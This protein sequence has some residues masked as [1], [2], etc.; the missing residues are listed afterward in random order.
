M[1]KGW[2]VVKAA[3]VAPPPAA[4]SFCGT[5]TFEIKVN[6][7]S[8][9][10]HT[11]AAGSDRLVIV[12]FSWVTV[13]RTLDSCTYGGVTMTEV[14]GSLHGSGSPGTKVKAFYLP[15][16]SL[17][18]NGA[19]V[20]DP[21]FSSTET[22]MRIG[23]S[24]KC[25]QDVPSPT[26]SCAGDA[27]TATAFFPR[28]VTSTSVPAGSVILLHGAHNDVST[29]ALSVDIGTNT[30]L[31]EAGEIYA[32]QGYVLDSGATGD[33]ASVWSVASESSNT[34]AAVHQV[35]VAY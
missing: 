33:R 7:T 4:A 25:L 12:Q 31:Q 10:N 9:F 20:I 30:T 35:I 2:G 13:G 23:C 11:L 26:I 21:A 14:T 18:A 17:P 22:A 3:E 27:G 28:T 16:A 8:T 24:V 32:L 6:Q 15:E 29:G 34:K 1:G 19:H 5:N